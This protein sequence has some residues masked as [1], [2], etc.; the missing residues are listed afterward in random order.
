[1][2]FLQKVLLRTVI[3]DGVGLDVVFLCVP[4]FD[5]RSLTQ[6]PAVFVQHRHKCQVFSRSHGMNS[7]R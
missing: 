7:G 1:M 5:G 2:L 4:D 6:G 3:D